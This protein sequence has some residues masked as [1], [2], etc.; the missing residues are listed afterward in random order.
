VV[1]SFGMGR[2]Y[3]NAACIN[4]AALGSANIDPNNSRS[5]N[6]PF[7]VSILLMA[8]DGITRS[9]MDVLRFVADMELH[10][11]ASWKRFGLMYWDCQVTFSRFIGFIYGQVSFGFLL[12]VLTSNDRI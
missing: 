9:S 8:A 12:F 10:V 5:E 1:L 2:G 4:L 11:M 3:Q 6:M 7:F